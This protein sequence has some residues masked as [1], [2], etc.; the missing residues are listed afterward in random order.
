MDLCGGTGLFSAVRFGVAHSTLDCRGRCLCRV[1]GS[2]SLNFLFL[3]VISFCLTVTRDEESVGFFYSRPKCPS[4]VS[5]CVHIG[6]R[7][8]I[9]RAGM[10]PAGAECQRRCIMLRVL[11]PL[12][13]SE[14][15]PVLVGS[16]KFWVL[17]CSANHGK[18][19]FELAVFSE[20]IPP[21]PSCM[22]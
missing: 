4:P 12:A 2:R 21:T 5:G 9:D 13:Y 10:L 20:G 15:F 22:I 17:S 11:G 19:L 6:P 7:P 16:Q 3:L 14:N 18:K 1:V 8:R